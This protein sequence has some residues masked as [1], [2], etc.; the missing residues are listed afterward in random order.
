MIQTSQLQTARDWLRS[1]SRVAVLTGAG[2][3]AESGVPTFRSSE[4][5]WRNFRAEELATAE[6]FHRDPAL[7]WTW[8]NWRR[9]TI[10]ACRPNLGHYALAELENQKPGLTLVTQNVD[11]LHNR[12]GSQRVLKIHGDIWWVLCLACNRIT[13]DLRV[14]LPEIP[15]HCSCGGLLRPGVVWFGESLPTAT[16][17]QAEA[18]VSE[19]ELL[20][21][22]GTSSVVY[23][24]ASLAPLALSR[25]ARVIEINT[26]ETPLSGAAAISLRGPSGELLPLLIDS[27]SKE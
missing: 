14:P 18:A 7:V 1:A 20:V 6:A 26:E 2:I 11:G 22:A 10:A 5:L 25:G 16:W 15:P 4:G 23:P 3:S 19:C 12:A 17:A 27:A 9:E 21:V 24:A 13:T 8:Y